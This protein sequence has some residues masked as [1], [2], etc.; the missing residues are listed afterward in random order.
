MKRSI[1]VLAPPA[2]ALAILAGCASTQAPNELRDARAAYQRA[3]ASP[4]AQTNR[5]GLMDARQALDA[6]EREYNAAPGSDD[7]K[8][9]G[10]VAQRKA[11][12]AET[13]GRAA[14]AKAKEEAAE[15]TYLQMQA[16]RAQQEAEKQRQAATV[17]ERRAKLALDRLGLAAKDEPRGTVITLPNANMFA[18][19]KADIMP[20]AKERLTE[21]ADAV[22]QV[23]AERAPQDV[24]RKIQLVGYT[25][26][27]GSDEHNM[28]LS[29]HRAEAVRT[30]FS[31]HGIDA[32]MMEAE[33]RGEAD[34]IADNGTS[35]GRAENRRVEVVVTR[36]PGAEPPALPPARRP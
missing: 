20:S 9:L 11:E 33:G 26:S 1:F 3:E 17:S 16:A 23:I 18:T 19:N 29:K 25:D 15:K 35:Q 10:Y 27:T 14:A 22:K 36:A 6:A 28:E 12:I 7:V 30:F 5:A 21:I 2:I 8:T 13:E 32:S 24:G 34:P 31:Q 4:A